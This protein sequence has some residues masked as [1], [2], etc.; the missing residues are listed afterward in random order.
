[1]V[2]EVDTASSNS[3]VVVTD[4]NKAMANNNRAILSR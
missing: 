4:N 1:V 2:V 3:K